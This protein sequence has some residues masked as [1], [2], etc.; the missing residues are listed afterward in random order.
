VSGGFFKLRATRSARRLTLVTLLGVL[1]ALGVGAYSLFAAPSKP[2]FALAVSPS[3]QT[4]TAGTPATYSATITRSGGFAG[5]V[6]LSVTGLPSG[7][8]ASFNPVSPV[9]GSSTTLTVSTAG[10]VATGSYPLTLSGVSGSL[11]H[12][13]SLTLI[14][15]STATFSLAVSPSAQTVTQDDAASYNISITRLNGFAGAVALAVSGLPKKVSATLTPAT[16]PASGTTAQLALVI[17]KNADTGTFTLTITGTNGP[18]SRT[19]T[20]TLNVEKKQ[21]FLIF[22]N[23]HGPLTPG[24]TTNIDLRLTN[25]NSFAIRVTQLN[26][27]VEEQTSNTVCSGTGNFTITPFTGFVDLP[28]N[29]TN[30]SL[31]SLVGSA[32]LPKIT[33]SDDPSHSQDAC[34]STVVTL[35]YNGT[36]VKP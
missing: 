4:V 15:Q 13:A 20:V 30:V 2:D 27:S 19:V 8:T 22:G 36:A 25:P 31:E 14:V 11:S 10:S 34:K 7:A 12:T 23:A 1:A 6:S 21:Q 5:A 18:I 17:D 9:S 16:I 32:R 29:V 3:S 33:F 28:A 24:A 26:V 35:Q